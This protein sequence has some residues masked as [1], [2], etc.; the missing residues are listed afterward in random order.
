MSEVKDYFYWSLDDLGREVT[1]RA[2]ILAIG[3]MG[4]GDVGGT[5]RLIEACGLLADRLIEHPDWDKWEALRR[6][7]ERLGRVIDEAL[8]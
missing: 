2:G 7:A 8:R 4:I 6:R 3:E 5:R 1:R